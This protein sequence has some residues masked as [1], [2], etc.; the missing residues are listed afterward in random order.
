[1]KVEP[2]RDGEGITMGLESEA[3]N[4]V[5]KKLNNREKEV[6]RGE[7]N[8]CLY[9]IDF[10]LYPYRSGWFRISMEIEFV[11]HCHVVIFIK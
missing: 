1:M 5:R 10:I 2:M 8:R 4:Q 6:N 11:T 9:L 7:C 3:L